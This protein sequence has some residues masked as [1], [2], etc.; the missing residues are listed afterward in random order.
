[1][2]EH[3][4]I[5]IKDAWRIYELIEELQE[6]FHQP[7]HYS[8][9]GDVEKWIKEK[10]VYSE[11]HHVYYKIVGEWFP[12]NEETGVVDAPASLTRRFGDGF[13]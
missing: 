9:P 8:K 4:T 11:L 5:S 13:K 1:M 2:K 10:G 12:V 3:V 6:F 7:M